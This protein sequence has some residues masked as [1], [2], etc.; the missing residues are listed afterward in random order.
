MNNSLEKFTPYVE[1]GL[2]RQVISP[3]GK[4]VL[5]NY[6]DKCTYE[7]AWDETTLNARGTVYEIETGK[8]VARA[9]PKF[10]NFGELS[11]EKQTEVLNSKNFEVYEKMDGSLG[12]VYYYDGEW[13]V[14]TR[15]SFTSDQ[16]IKGKE[17][18]DEKYDMSG[19]PE[20]LTI[21]VEIIYPENRI[22]VD[23]GD[24]EELVVLGCYDYDG[25]G[26]RGNLTAA[27]AG[28]RVAPSYKFSSISELQTHL[29]TLDHNE[30]GYVVRFGNGERVKFKSAEYLAIARIMSNM[31]PLTFWERM[32]NGIIDREFLQQLP[33][34]FRDESDS[35]CDILESQY[36]RVYADVV[37]DAE[38]T[39]KGVNLEP[40]H[41]GFY[42]NQHKKMIGL[43]LK[44]NDLKNSGAVFPYLLGRDKAVDKYIMKQIKPT[45]NVLRNI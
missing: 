31:S 27:F 8:V 3:C 37:G 34:E 13:R 6:T 28:M 10:F 19:I 12:I 33:E 41:P 44:E 22:I 16:A 14:N 39:L 36:D 43:Y 7:R 42:C 11:P 40:M 24:K 9:F 15:G 17:I 1:Q 20:E 45:G 4:L 29:E 32:E 30:E 38:R 26:M 2:L 18:L 21:L 23:Y 35:I 25:F 5:W